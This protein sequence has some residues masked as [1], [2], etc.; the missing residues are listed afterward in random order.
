[1]TKIKTKSWQKE[2]NKRFTNCYRGD[3]GLG[4]NY[5]QEPIYE[6]ATDNPKDIVDF[7]SR[8][9]QAVVE[10]LA[11]EKEIENV[12]Y[13]RTSAIE[14]SAKIFQLGK[15]FNR[16]S[17]EKIVENKIAYEINQRRQEVLKKGKK[18]TK[19]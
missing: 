5:P 18:W 2:F 14:A 6:W 12:R 9:L 8:L 13:G 15:R 10:D 19:T 1:M 7:I 16:L 17:I 4:G 3:S 11:G